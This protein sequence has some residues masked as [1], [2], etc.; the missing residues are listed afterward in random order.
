MPLIAT[1]RRCDST[2]D[3]PG[4]AN[5]LSVNLRFR[6]A[7]LCTHSLCVCEGSQCMHVCHRCLYDLHLNKWIVDAIISKTQLSTATIRL[8]HTHEFSY[9]KNKTILI[10]IIATSTVL[11]HLPLF[12][13]FKAVLGARGGT[14]SFGVWDNVAGRLALC[15]WHPAEA[16][17]GPVRDQWEYTMPITHGAVR[18][19]S[20]AGPGWAGF[21]TMGCLGHTEKRDGGR[22]EDQ[23]GDSETED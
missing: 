1:V 17:Y 13:H 20:G 23:R 14:S 9:Q 22:K 10:H 3:P 7:C 2:E 5:R 15:F 11:H 19:A 18:R 6:L 4:W 16:Q 21:Q 8:S 12:W